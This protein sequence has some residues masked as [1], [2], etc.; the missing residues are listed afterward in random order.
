[1]EGAG[2]M[3]KTVRAIVLTTALLAST[4]AAASSASAVTWHSLGDTA[5]TATGGTVDFTVTGSPPIP[6]EHCY[7]ST[8][9]GTLNAPEATPVW[10]AM[11]MTTAMFCG[12]LVGQTLR[13]EC[14]ST[15]TAHNQTGVTIIGVLDTT[16]GFYQG[17]TK[18]C[19]FNGQIDVT[20]TN[21]VPPS[22]FG[23]LTLPTPGTMRTGA[24][25][26]PFFG[27][28]EPMWLSH[29]TYTITTATGGPSAPHLGPVIIRTA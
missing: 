22:T 28:N 2:S 7:S 10:R 12:F 4:L 20:Y 8:T 6:Y 5:F 17:V 14:S 11:T 23:K 9:T 26:S 1:M 24:G 16:C 25:C 19:D 13:N 29:Q 21:P 27:S 3:R 15:F 18:V